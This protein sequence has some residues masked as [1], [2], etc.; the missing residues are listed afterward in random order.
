[1][2]GDGDIQINRMNGSDNDTVYNNSSGWNQTEAWWDEV[3]FDSVALRL[4]YSS[5]G[6]A[7]D[8]SINNTSEASSF[9]QSDPYTYET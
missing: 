2:Y 6:N 3:N 8:R 7:S 5:M 9:W 4:R 1:M